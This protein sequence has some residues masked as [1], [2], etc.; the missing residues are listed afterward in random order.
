M[1]EI[2]DVKLVSCHPKSQLE[3]RIDELDSRVLHLQNQ[4]SSLICAMTP[5]DPKFAELLEQLRKK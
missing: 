1:T 5:P 4:M 3:K 2:K